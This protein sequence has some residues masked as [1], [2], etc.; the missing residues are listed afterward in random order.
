MEKKS[1]A[2]EVWRCIT[3]QDRSRT[4]KNVP[5]TKK[6]MAA[7]GR[8]RVISDTVIIGIKIRLEIIRT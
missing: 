2:E 7:M 6:I 8:L 4:L 5:A 3:D 1:P